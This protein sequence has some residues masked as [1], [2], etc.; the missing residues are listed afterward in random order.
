MGLDVTQSKFES[1]KTEFR[2][3]DSDASAMHWIL[4]VREDRC[5]VSTASK[6]LLGQRRRGQSLDLLANWME[7]G[8]MSRSFILKSTQQD[9]ALHRIW[10]AL[11]RLSNENCWIIGKNL[12]NAIRGAL[13]LKLLNDS[14]ANPSSRSSLIDRRTS[15]RREEDDPPGD[16]SPPPESVPDAMKSLLLLRG[17]E[18]EAP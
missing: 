12:V 14:I 4:S 17:L 11:R 3:R 15:R 6:A 7:V 8:H 2:R 1:R 18:D 9:E 16:E 10:Y 13:L 5:A